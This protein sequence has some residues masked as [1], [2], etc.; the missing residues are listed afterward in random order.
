M[1]VPTSNYRQMRGRSVGRSVGHHRWGRERKGRGDRG[2]GGNREGESPQNERTNERERNLLS[3]SSSC[4]CP[5]WL[6]IIPAIAAAGFFL[7]WRRIVRPIQGGAIRPKSCS[8]HGLQEGL[9]VVLRDTAAVSQQC[10]R[11]KLD[12]FN[13]F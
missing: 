8:Q 11:Q 4:P 3:S 1:Y 10:H 6:S 13:F 9:V 7:Y 2:S 5:V 12:S